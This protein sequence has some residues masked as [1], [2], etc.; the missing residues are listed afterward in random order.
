MAVA[1][2]RPDDPSANAESAATVV[3]PLLDAV[4]GGRT[5]IPIRFWDGSRLGPADGIGE[6]AFTS[7]DAMRRILWAPGELGF[8]RA[9]IVGEMEVRGPMPEVLRAMQNGTPE[10]ISAR[11]AAAPVLIR[12]AR[13]L[14]AIGKPLPAPPEEATPTGRLHSIRRDRHVIGH[15]YDVGNRFYEIVLGPSMTY[16]CARFVN[17]DMTLAEA[18]SAKHELVCRKLGLSEIS[19]LSG[20]S[21][22]PRLLD[23]GCGWGELAIHAATHHGAEVVGVTISAQQ[24]EYARLR[25]AEA[26]VDDRVEIRLEDYREVGDGPFD[27]ISSIGMAEHVGKR[28]MTR[29]FE[30]LVS[31]LRPG[32]RLMNHA[33]AFVGGSR[34]SSSSFIGRYVFPDGEL[35]DLADTVRCMQAAGFEVR[36]V[37]NLRE[38]YALTL[39]RWVHNLEENWD[40]VVA[41]VGERRARVWLLYMSGSINGFDDGRLQL[42]QTVGVKPHDD[43]RSGM[44]RTRVDWG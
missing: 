14:D 37:E 5:P 38:H 7:P 15:H 23:V 8:A 20:G 32:G 12:T 30:A 16:S 26:G 6:I 25:V 2:K 13:R 44:P 36:D 19:A 42:Q 17:D 22:R 27:A 24:A 31:L 34:V 35:L 4:L 1:D 28:N 39:R 33:I 40:A 41:E 21:R 43:G 18:Q 10:V 29:Y 3:Q 11:L 9:Y